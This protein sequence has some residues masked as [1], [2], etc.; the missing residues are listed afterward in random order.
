L[1]KVLEVMNTN[2]TIWKRFKWVH[3]HLDVICYSEFA[4]M[5]F[6]DSIK[7]LN[8]IATQSNVTY[9][10]VY[11]INHVSMFLQVGFWFAAFLFRCLKS[12]REMDNSM[13]IKS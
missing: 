6:Y 12:S 5:M 9:L 1:L 8:L 11:Y 2:T 3:V 13:E 10:K 7:S 4:F